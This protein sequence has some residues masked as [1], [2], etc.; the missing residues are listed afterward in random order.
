[1][2]A[3]YQAKKLYSKHG[4]SFERDLCHYLE[5]GIVV[6][7]PDRFLM[8]KAINKDLGDDVWNPEFVN[9]WYVQIAV[10]KDCLKWFLSQAPYQL[11]FVAWRRWKAKGNP[12]KY[13]PT[14]SFARFVS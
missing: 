2:N 12:I 3:L 9:S 1:M 13:Y 6:A 4:L 11:P 5:H 8:A 10:G 14:E 7:H